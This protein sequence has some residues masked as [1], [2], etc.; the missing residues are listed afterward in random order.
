ML[1][2]FTQLR[3]SVNDRIAHIEMNRPEKRNALSPTLRRELVAALK[4]AEA[5]DEVTL[6]LLS[7]A[8]KSFCA[9]YDMSRFDDGPGE[10]DHANIDGYLTSKHFESWTG[11]F[12]RSCHRDW[13]TIWDLL[14]PVVAKVQGYCLAGGSEIMSMC[15]IAFVADDAVLGY[16]PTRAQGTPDL[17]YFPWK[18]SMARAKYL[19][20]TGNT[21]S[22]K[23]AAE[24]GWVAKSFPAEEL[25]E[26]VLR[27]LRPMSGID[28][29]LLA[30]NKIAVNQAYEGMGFRTHLQNGWSWHAM[31]TRVRPGAGDF[32]RIAEEQ[33][34]RA[35]IAWRDGPFRKEGFPF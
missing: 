9:G 2:E 4:Q 23:E 17:A 10:T 30:A 16:P 1:M 6:V 5:D 19:Q 35:A 21:V 12:P 27:E 24:M 8:G 13:F 33:G 15:D 22:G 25:D 14:K 7:G 20:L 32:G 3:Y 31:S 28:P 34:M 26:A 18:L 29:A 11:Q